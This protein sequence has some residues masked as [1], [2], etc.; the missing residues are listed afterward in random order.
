MLRC[1]ACHPLGPM[2]V[3]DLTGTLP[4]ASKGLALCVYSVSLNSICSRP[5]MWQCG[6]RASRL[7]RA[8]GQHLRLRP[9]LLVYQ[10][11][12]SPG[13]WRGLRDAPGIGDLELEVPG[14][15]ALEGVEE[16]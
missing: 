8:F 16:V 15:A 7:H 5:Q 10:Y 13:V 1:I 14:V 12:L 11:M 2:M 3:A 9:R 6:I 4:P